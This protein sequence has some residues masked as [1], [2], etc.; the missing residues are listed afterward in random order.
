MQPIHV[1]RPGT[2]RGH[3]LGAAEIAQLAEGYDP[4]LHE[5]PI[6]VG[7]PADG[8]PAY[9]WVASLAADADGLHATARDVA[10][11]LAEAVAAGRYR[12]VSASLYPPGAAHHPAPESEHW[13]LRHVGFLGAQ[14]PVV[15]GLRPVS[16]GEAGDDVVTVEVSLAEHPWIWG[17]VARL[18]RSLRDRLIDEADLETADRVL[19][20]YHIDEL[21]REAERAVPDDSPAPAFAEPE[22]AAQETDMATARPSPPEP[23]DLAEREAQLTARA[24]ELDARTAALDT[25]DAQ[26]AAREATDLAERLVSE[27]R[28]LPRDQ[29]PLAA[30]LAAVPAAGD[31]PTVEFA[32][33]AGAAPAA[34]PAGAYLRHLLAGLPV[35][36]DYAE[37]AA[38]DRDPPPSAPAAGLT[39]PAGHVVDPEGERTYRRI[40]DLAERERIPFEEA[41]RRTAQEGG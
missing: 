24:A 11:E 12:K 7:H 35:Q 17:T 31:G 20:D 27:G 10:V 29:A 34:R 13:Y 16:L 5:A 41:V 23:A 2:F 3:T 28:I 21:A 39:L 32:E 38:A 25:R 40:V 36:V 8:A 18:F 22:P 19:P 6:V 14:A 1:L 15:K 33:S 30:L 26:H 9:G 37:R 4:A